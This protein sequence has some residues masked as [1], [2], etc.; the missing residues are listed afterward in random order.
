MDA[1][2]A[3]SRARIQLQASHPFFAY[4]LFYMRAREDKSVRTMG[5]SKNGDFV[6]GKEFVEA[7]PDAHL[8]FILCH[9][10]M[11]LA[12]EHT[13][14]SRRKE[15]TALAVAPDGQVVTVWNLA[16]DY[17]INAM[18]SREGLSC[19]CDV[20]LDE[21]FN[22]LI[23]EEVY[24]ELMKRFKKNASKDGKICV[25]QGVLDGEKL[26][27][28]DADAKQGEGVNAKQGKNAEGVREDV[29]WKDVLNEANTFAKMRG[30]SPA[31]ME[32]E[33]ESVTYRK[34]NWRG[35][36]HKYVQSFLPFDYTYSKR[37]RRRG[38]DVFFPSMKK[39]G[40]KVVVAVDTS[41]SISS[42]QLGVFYNEML[43]VRDSF[44]NCELVVVMCDAEVTGEFKVVNHD[45]ILDKIK[46][47]GGGGTSFVPAVEYANEK[48]KDAASIIYLTDGCGE[49]PE[50]SKLPVIWALT[51]D[52]EVPFGKKL[53]LDDV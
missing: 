26:E 13:E 1:R 2:D 37:N 20:L 11:H 25:P 23:T 41:G 30:K 47:T 3:I 6:Y 44:G 31:G 43:S 40:I 48:H 45:N 27:E 53:L 29:S 36:L 9:E 32:R 21:K 46:F 8:Q 5:V 15:R 35:M 50:K 51:Q 33:F 38:G 4:L 12:L 18:L 10:V 16:G 22:G 49:F 34:R 14:P 19:P 24:D 42:K 28:K 17:V 39:E 52:C 7:L